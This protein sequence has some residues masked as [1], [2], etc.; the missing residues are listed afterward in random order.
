MEVHADRVAVMGAHGPLLAATSLRVG[1]GGLAVV[2]GEPN[3]GHTAFGLALTGR[4]SP[5]AGSVSPDA[6]TLRAHAVLVDSPAVTAPEPNLRTADVVAEELALAGARPRRAAVAR[7]LE[8]H[9]LSPDARFETVPAAAR[10]ALLTGLAAA[11]PGVAL[12]VL[13][14]P[15]RHSGD[16]G[17]WWPTALAQAEAG[18]AVVVLC[19]TAAAHRL[20]LTPARL[21][22]SDQPAPLETLPLENLT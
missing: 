13:D 10:V 2:A 8:T 4:I 1:S 3:D 21:G 9:G 15:D 7:V 12:L 6:A 16:P 22:E 5:S 14:T 11:R 19:G 17:D 20:P 18:R